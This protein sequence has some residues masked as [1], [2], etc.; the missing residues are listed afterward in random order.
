LARAGRDAVLDPEFLADLRYW[1]KTD[2]GTALKILDLMEAVLR[3]PFE[4][5]GKPEPLRFELQGCWSRRIT[6]EH[7]IVYRVER[8]R[9]VFLEGRYHY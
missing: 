5:I 1:L 8:D 3:E 2:R 9:I 6:Q 4:G 7:R